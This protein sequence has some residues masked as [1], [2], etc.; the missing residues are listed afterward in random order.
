MA[1]IENPWGFFGEKDD[2]RKVSDERKKKTKTH[3]KV[4]L[5]NGKIALPILPIEIKYTPRYRQMKFISMLSDPTSKLPRS[6]SNSWR[7]ARSRGRN[8]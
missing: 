1:S 8:V 5:P 3:M 2:D 4:T 6:S 7:V